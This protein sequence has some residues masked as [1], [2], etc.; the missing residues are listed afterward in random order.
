VF[1]DCPAGFVGRL[2]KRKREVDM[3]RRFVRLGLVGLALVAISAVGASPAAA[4]KAKTKTI[5]ATFNQCLSTAVAIPDFSGTAPSNG[6]SV[7]QTVNVPNFRGKPQ[8]GVVTAFSIAGIRITHTFDSDLTINLISPGGVVV[9][10]ANRRGANG[11]GYGNGAASCS[12]GLVLFSDTFPTPIRTPGNTG[13][14]GNDPITGSFHPEGNLAAFVGG[15][16]K[17]NWVLAVTDGAGADVGAINAF[18]LSF[19]YTYRKGPKK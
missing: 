4:K 18:S 3:R 15:P 13:N 16:A 10:L 17:G 2:S 14:A 7:L 5:T 11:D 12:G 6:A 9:T 19:T 1:T 8:T